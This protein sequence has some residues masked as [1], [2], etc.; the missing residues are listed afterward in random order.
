MELDPRWRGTRSPS[1][2]PMWGARGCAA[3]LPPCGR[4]ARDLCF[5]RSRAASD[6]T[7]RGTG[8]A[9]GLPGRLAEVDRRPCIRHACVGGC[10]PAS[11]TAA[12]G[13]G[14]SPASGAPASCGDGDPASTVPPSGGGGGPPSGTSPA[15]GGA[16]PPSIDPVPP[17]SGT[18]AV[19]ASSG[20]PVNAAPPEHAVNQ[21][22]SAT[23]MSRT[24]IASPS[25]AFGPPAPT[26]RG[27]GGGGAHLSNIPEPCR[28]G[29][30]LAR[31]ACPA[32]G[33]EHRRGRLAAHEDPT[34]VLPHVGGH[35]EVVQDRLGVSHVP[36]ERRAVVESSCLPPARRQS[37]S[38]QRRFRWR[39]RRRSGG[40]RICRGV[41][42]PPSRTAR[43]RSATAS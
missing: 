27:D 15:S 25:Y 20:V 29:T 38:P 35:G 16:L 19:P 8:R 24:R 4:H 23:Q 22:E 14:G 43:Q 37:G 11:G 7:G 3:R 21:H 28:A 30:R 1:A 31:R 6:R 10:G 9:A 33:S 12:V 41:G 2:S 36:L 40:A 26:G 42:C 34:G 18:D 32:C 13:G 5:G 17:A 39:G